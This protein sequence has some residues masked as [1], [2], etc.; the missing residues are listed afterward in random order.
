MFT[1]SRLLMLLNGHYADR[2]RET[3]ARARLCTA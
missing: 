3:G 2:K 1:A